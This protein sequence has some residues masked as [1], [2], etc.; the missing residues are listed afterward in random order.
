MLEGDSPPT[1]LSG[2]S[3]M[4]TFAGCMNERL[5]L[6]TGMILA[7]TTGTQLAAIERIALNWPAS[8]FARE[9][10]CPC[11]SLKLLVLGVSSQA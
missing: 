11:Q 1:L 10:D 2:C 4:F 7:R 6:A 8:G 5:G 3:D 9:A